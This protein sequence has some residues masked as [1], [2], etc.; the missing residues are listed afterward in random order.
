MRRDNAWPAVAIAGI[1]LLGLFVRV[2][3][4]QARPWVGHDEAN[5]LVF[6]S[7]QWL[8]YRELASTGMP[9][10]LSIA[11]AGDWRKF[12]EAGDA[13]VPLRGDP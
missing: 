9:P 10:V 3:S 2:A 1:L 13:V 4:V 5:T 8:S 7:C 12:V 6:A 11:L